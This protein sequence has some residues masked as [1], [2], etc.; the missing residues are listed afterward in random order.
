MSSQFVRSSALFAALFI[1]AA[2]LPSSLEAQRSATADRGNTAAQASTVATPAPVAH[3]DSAPAAGRRVAPAG[4]TRLVQ[5]SPV[6]LDQLQ[7]ES[8][9]VGVG[10]NLAMM[11]TGAAAVVIG[12]MVGGDGGTL[13]ALG[14]GVFGLVGLYRFLR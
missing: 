13:I 8:S 6:G 5:T 4:I 12:L 11:G 1:G 7:E 9:H 10:S 14:G 3:A 2:V